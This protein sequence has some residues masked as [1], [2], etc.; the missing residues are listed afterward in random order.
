MPSRTAADSSAIAPHHPVG[1]APGVPFDLVLLAVAVGG[2]SFSAPLIASMAA[3]ALA[4]A[5][6]RNA[7]AVGVL[8]PVVGLRR[9]L[10][11][12]VRG[13]GR[14]TF[15]LCVASGAILALHFGL[16]LPSLKL[17]SVASSTALG[18]TTP[19]WT[20]VL[21]RLRGQRAPGLVWAGAVVAMAGVVLLTGVDLSLS[22]EALAGDAL[23]LGG[24]I[25]AA[26]YVL[27]GAEV[28]RTVST[29]SYTLICYGVCAVALLGVCLAAGVD[30]GGGYSAETWLKLVALTGCAQLL[31]HTLFNRVVHGLGATV[32]STAIL[33]EAPGAALIAAVWLGQNPPAGV[34]VALTVI[35]AGLTMVILAN[36]RTPAAA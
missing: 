4:I 21:L 36:R 28:R 22:P 13:M 1:R 2:V 26:G 10:R 32:T 7:M 6:W 12:E 27:I 23:A 17:T 35:L 14:R 29:T 24:G 30:L 19:V 34:Y 15:W 5:F 31:G 25:A 18:T 9:G 8:A 16:W 11:D 3:P 33:L 20:L